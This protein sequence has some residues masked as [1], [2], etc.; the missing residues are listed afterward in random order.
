[1]LY[2]ANCAEPTTPGRKDV[3]GGHLSAMGMCRR[4]TRPSSLP[5]CPDWAMSAPPWQ[6]LSLSGAC[7]SSS[8]TTGLQGVVVPDTLMPTAAMLSFQPARTGAGPARGQKNVHLSFQPA[9]RVAW[10]HSATGH[11]E[12][13]QAKIYTSCD[14]NSS[15]KKLQKHAWWNKSQVDQISN[16]R[17]H[18]QVLRWLH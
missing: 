11:P 4:P 9:R 12:H 14:T 16:F 1:M 15:R 13:R 17:E 10:A 8:N 5:C 7:S 6:A 3:R 2:A 18:L